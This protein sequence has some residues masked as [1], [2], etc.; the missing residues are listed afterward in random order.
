MHLLRVGALTRHHSALYAVSHSLQQ[1]L[2]SQLGTSLAESCTQ[3]HSSRHF[4]SKCTPEVLAEFRDNIAEFAKTSIAIHAEEVDKTN[5]F[6][7]TADLWKEMGDFGLLGK[8][9]VSC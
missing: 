5:D 9:S 2:N 1:L 4:S 3:Q 6:P 8:C 7:K